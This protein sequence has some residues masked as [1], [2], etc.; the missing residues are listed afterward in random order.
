MKITIT[1]NTCSAFIF[2]APLLKSYFKCIKVYIIKTIIGKR[3]GYNFKLSAMSPLTRATK[4]L[5]RPQPGHSICSN[6]LKGQANIC[7]CNQST[8]DMKT[9]KT[10]LFNMPLQTIPAL[11]KDFLTKYISPLPAHC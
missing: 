2:L 5:C 6:F 9:N 1:A 11:L 3:P 10:I 4:L 7:S 8:M